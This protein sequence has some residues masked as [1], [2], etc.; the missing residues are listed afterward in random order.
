MS[1]CSHPHERQHHHPHLPHPIFT[2]FLGLSL[3]DPS[4]HLRFADHLQLWM[5]TLLLW[6]PYDV[7]QEMAGV[8]LVC[9]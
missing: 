1:P 7:G 8:S 4:H 3:H 2:L 6:D 9:S 5:G